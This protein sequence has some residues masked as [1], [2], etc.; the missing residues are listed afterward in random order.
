MPKAKKTPSESEWARRSVTRESIA[1]ESVI[2][3][4]VIKKEGVSK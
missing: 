4:V 3:G 1:P 2:V